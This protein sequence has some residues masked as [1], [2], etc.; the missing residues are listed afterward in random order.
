VVSVTLLSERERT[1]ITRMTTRGHVTE[2]WLAVVGLVAAAVGT[3]MYYA[4]SNWYLANLVEG[5]YLGMFIGA[6]LLLATGFGIFARKA[7]LDDQGWTTRVTTGLVAL[8]LAL[9][10]AITFALIWIL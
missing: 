8:G 3:Y 10:G 4:P 1:E 5:W 2:W 6:G 7:F 9:A